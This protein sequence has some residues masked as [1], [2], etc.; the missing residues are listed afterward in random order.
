MIAA[1]AGPSLGKAYF[2]YV[3]VAVCAGL[4]SS[5][6]G[7]TIGCARMKATRGSRYDNTENSDK[8]DNT[9]TDS[10]NHN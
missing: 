3:Y 10:N 2:F 7:S 9:N 8:T 6:R 5:M 4:R 1:I